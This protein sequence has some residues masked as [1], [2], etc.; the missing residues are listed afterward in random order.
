MPASRAA[1]TPGTESSTTTQSNGCSFIAIAACRKRSGNGLPRGTWLE[2]KMRPSNRSHRPVRPSVK[3]HLLRRARACDAG[4][5]AVAPAAPAIASFMPGT[6]CKRRVAEGCVGDRLH[7][8]E[9]VVRQLAA[10]LRLD[11]LDAGLQRP[12]H[13]AAHR[14]LDRP[15]EALALQGA[16]RS[17]C[18]QSGSLSTSTPSQSKMTSTAAVVLSEAKDLIGGSP[19]HPATLP[20]RTEGA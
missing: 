5:E 8:L 19:P 2:L 12:A 13:Q 11:D 15:V 6:G 20:C 7:L 9:E 10:E 4:R 14:L 3:L 18:W 17:S 16:R 1:C